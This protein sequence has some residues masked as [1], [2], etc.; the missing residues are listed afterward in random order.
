M[1][2]PQRPTKTVGMALN[3]Q[4]M[5]TEQ[6]P[7]QALLPKA[8]SIISKSQF[9]DYEPA[10]IDYTDLSAINREL[11]DLR[12]RLHRIRKEMQN[13]DRIAL[14]K[15]YNYESQKKRIMISLTGSSVAEREAMAELLCEEA[16]TEMLVAQQ[17][18]KELTQHNRDLRTELDSLREI[19][20][21]NR[22]V[23]DLQ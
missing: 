4:Q 22:R 5:T 8:E 9:Y 6:V 15:K 17:V 7:S 12:T 21:N 18:S 16:Y 3:G 23:I 10:T 13:A 1:A 11:N 19:S 20:M 2:D 14:S